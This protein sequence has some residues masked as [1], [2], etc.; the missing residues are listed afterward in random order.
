MNGDPA[1]DPVE[2]LMV[3]DNPADVRL[4]WEALKGW[5]R[6]SRLRVAQNGEEALDILRKQGRHAGEPRP[7]LVFLDLNLPKQDGREILAEIKSDEQLKMI[8][9]IVLTTSSAEADIVNTYN[10]H[11]N[12]YVIKP[13]NLDDFMAAIRSIESFWGEIA[14]LP[15]E[16]VSGA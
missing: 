12:S 9:V 8:P 5:K 15:P 16:G 2:I 4:T 7:D 6:K 10:L 11:A 3:D 1:D 14:S 13:I